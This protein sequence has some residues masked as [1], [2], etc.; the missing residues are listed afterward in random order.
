MVKA[1]FLNSEAV[2]W[3]KANA[4]LNA[5]LVDQPFP[6][7]PPW[8]V[9]THIRFTHTERQLSSS[10]NYFVLKTLQVKVRTTPPDQYDTINTTP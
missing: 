3:A 1:D 2:C 4:V 10:L 6:V 9:I 8:Q 5:Q 7:N